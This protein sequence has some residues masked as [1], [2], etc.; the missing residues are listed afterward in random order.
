MRALMGL[1][2]HLK[3]AYNF[4][5]VGGELCGGLGGS[6]R[7]LQMMGEWWQAR[8]SCVL[9]FVIMYRLAYR[10]SWSVQHARTHGC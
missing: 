7:D 3:C 6:H 2:Y 1:T 4:G 9:L 8:V 10:A 5:K